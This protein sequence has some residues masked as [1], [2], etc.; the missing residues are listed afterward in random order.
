MSKQ[1]NIG[2]T[3]PL[4][5]EPSNHDTSDNEPLALR[6]EIYALLAY[7]LRQPPNTAALDWLS[8]LPITPSPDVNADPYSMTQAWALLSNV[9]KHTSANAAAEEYQ[10]LFIGIGRG[11]VLP[12]AS[13]YKCGALMDQPLVL[14]R[15]DLC[16]LGISR[17]PHIKEPED[18]IAAL[19]EVMALLLQQEPIKISSQ[20]FNRHISDWFT[21]LF[22][23]ITN[24]K[25][26]PFYSAVA[27]LMV[28]FLALE[29]VSFSQ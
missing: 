8:N 7:L 22:N 27:L 5:N 10:N 21:T 29:Q 1:A 9:A 3:Q 6:I 12:F 11:D 13:W 17:Q 25:N 15:R 16:T 28:N 20:F 23:D 24:T 2:Q 18:H 26:N 4:T 19:F 14:L